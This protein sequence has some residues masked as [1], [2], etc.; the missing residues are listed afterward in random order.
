VVNLISNDV[1]RFDQFMVMAH[2]LYLAPMELV[3]CVWLAW[4]EVGVACLGMSKDKQPN[5]D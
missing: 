5:R 2:F 3:V 1:N 4:R